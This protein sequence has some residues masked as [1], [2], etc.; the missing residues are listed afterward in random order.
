MLLLLL[1]LFI[2]LFIYLFFFFI[3]YLFFFFFFCYFT[4]RKRTKGKNMLNPVLDTNNVLM[5]LLTKL[6]VLFTDTSYRIFTEHI[7]QYL[8]G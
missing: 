4:K 3:F 5:F 1:L 7:V 6:K 8:Y 2:Y